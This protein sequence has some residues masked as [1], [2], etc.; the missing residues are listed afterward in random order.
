MLEQ[1]TL[2]FLLKAY[3]GKLCKGKQNKNLE[4]KIKGNYNG[5]YNYR[6]ARA[7]SYCIK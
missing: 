4:D 7:F 1:R 6:I 2:L 5:V 3:R